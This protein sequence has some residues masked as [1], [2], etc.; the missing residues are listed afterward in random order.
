MPT[1]CSH[2]IWQTEASKSVLNFHS[3]L[4]TYLSF[5]IPTVVCLM[6]FLAFKWMIWCLY[7]LVLDPHGLEL[8]EQ[9]LEYKAVVMQLA[10]KPTQNLNWKPY[11][12]LDFLLTYLLSWA[13]ITG[14]RAA[15]TPPSH[16]SSSP[17]QNLLR[18]VRD[19]VPQ[20]IWQASARCRPRYFEY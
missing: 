13:C 6:T 12:V 2:G 8:C 18:V 7:L 15:E 14:R 10:P 11:L 3:A 20:A 9:F 1:L 17:P 5:M 4:P 19:S 16:L